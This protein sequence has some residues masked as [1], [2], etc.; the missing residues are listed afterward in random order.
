MKQLHAA[1]LTKSN[2]PPIFTSSNVACLYFVRYSSV[3]CFLIIW[4]SVHAN[5]FT[6]YWRRLQLQFTKVVSTG[7]T[8]AHALMVLGQATRTTFSSDIMV[9]W[10]GACDPV[11]EHRGD[12]QSDTRANCTPDPNLALMDLGRKYPLRRGFLHFRASLDWCK[13]RGRQRAILAYEISWFLF[14]LPVISL[15]NYVIR[16]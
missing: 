5:V 12:L 6:Q 16:C 2:C 8:Y 4:Y 11:I 1:L 7:H 14:D 15:K 13:S 9:T 3:C 10:R